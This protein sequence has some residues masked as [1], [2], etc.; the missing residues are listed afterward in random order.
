MRVRR[1]ILASSF[2]AGLV[3]SSPS[4]AQST[5]PTRSCESLT[6]LSLPHATIVSAQAVAAGPVALATI[7]G[8]VNLDVPARCEVHGISRPSAD[9]EIRFEVW[10]PVNGWN[11]KYQQKGNGGFAGSINRAAWR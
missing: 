3:V 5:A 1:L 11:G 7:R 10:L 4:Q 9:S 8:P 2:V 6:M